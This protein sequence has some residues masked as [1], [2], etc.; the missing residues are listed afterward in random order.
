MKSWARCSTQ[1]R[2]DNTFALNLWQVEAFF[3]DNLNCL[4]KRNEKVQNAMVET[5]VGSGLPVGG[6]D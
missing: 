1:P 5:Q 6:K 3:T 2:S 4:C